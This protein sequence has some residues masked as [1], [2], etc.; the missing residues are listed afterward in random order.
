MT[1]PMRRMRC[2]D[3]DVGAA[4]RRGGVVAA[5]DAGEDRVQIVVLGLFVWVELLDQEPLDISQP[6]DRLGGTA[7]VEV[8]GDVADA[9]KVGPQGA[10]FGAEAA[11]ERGFLAAEPVRRG[12][13]PQR[14]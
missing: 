7:R 11:R 5:E 9:S 2:A 12:G 10:V 3:L 6:G 1:L 14:P 13:V 8:V 4:H